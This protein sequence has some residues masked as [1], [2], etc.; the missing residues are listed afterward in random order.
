MLLLVSLLPWVNFSCV[1]NGLNISKTDYMGKNGTY[2]QRYRMIPVI[3]RSSKVNYRAIA[4]IFIRAKI[5]STFFYFLSSSEKISNVNYFPSSSAS[6]L[7]HFP[8][9]CVRTN[10]NIFWRPYAGSNVFVMLSVKDS[11]CKQVHCF[12]LWCTDW[13]TCSV[14][15]H[16]SEFLSFHKC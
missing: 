14:N 6:L 16:F 7:K 13:R 3:I 4:L 10:F 8:F 1:R 9:A 12:H 2:K 15:S 5:I 11:D